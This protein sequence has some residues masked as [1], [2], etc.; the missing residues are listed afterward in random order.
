M[1]NVTVGSAEC[2]AHPITDAKSRI[3]NQ[4]SRLFWCRDS[5]KEVTD[6]SVLHTRSGW[7]IVEKEKHGNAATKIISC[8]QSVR[9]YWTAAE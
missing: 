7:T 1:L 9:P 4:L 2:A 6:L 5:Q 3:F 8:A